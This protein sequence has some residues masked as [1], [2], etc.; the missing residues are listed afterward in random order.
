MK[1]GTYGNANTNFAKYA[2]AKF[3][4]H[5][6]N[7]EDFQFCGCG[8]NALALITGVNPK[9]IKGKAH[10]PDRFMVKFLREQGFSVFEITKANLT[11]KRTISYPITDQNVVLYSS[12]VRRGEA[13]WSVMYSSYSFHNFSITSM[14]MYQLINWP[15]LSAYCIFSESFR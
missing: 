12:L 8:P 5:L 15:L 6:F 14:N 1:F 2:A 4:L 13:T 7:K 9:E 11:K 10:A 3:P